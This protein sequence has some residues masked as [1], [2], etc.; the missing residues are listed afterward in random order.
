MI[1]LTFPLMEE[2][3]STEVVVD[4][5]GWGWRVVLEIHIGKNVLGTSTPG[6]P[7]ENTGVSGLSH[8]VFPVQ[9]S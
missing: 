3:G 1:S 2:V 6:H 4:I 9:E 8:P 7:L 5:R